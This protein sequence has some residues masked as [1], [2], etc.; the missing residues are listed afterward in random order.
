MNRLMSSTRHVD[1]EGE[2]SDLPD[3]GITLWPVREMGNL[4]F[5]PRLL[6]SLLL[7][8]VETGKLIAL[9]HMSLR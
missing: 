7:F 6:S 4:R 9:Q 2:L 5:Q 8:E 3:Q 1:S